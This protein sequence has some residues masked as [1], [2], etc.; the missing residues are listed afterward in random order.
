MGS[1]RAGGSGAARRAA[2]VLCFD[3]EGEV[4]LLEWQ[5]PVNGRRLYEP[6]GGGVEEGESDVEAAARELHEETGLAALLDE[7]WSLE[8]ER[9][10][11]W[12]GKRY[13][14]PERFYGLR[15]GIAFTPV[16]TSLT[17][18]ERTT[19]RGHRWMSIDELST[20]ELP[21]EPPDVAKV[22]ER[23]MEMRPGGGALP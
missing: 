4:L 10:F 14:G 13:V 9:D 5:D 20:T 18:G 21:L 7:A 2:R 19:L 17:A 6:P 12:A 16:P 15:I 11:S 3:D 23:L 1:E 8:V 22:A